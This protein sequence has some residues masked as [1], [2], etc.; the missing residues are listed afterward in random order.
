MRLQTKLMCITIIP[1]LLLFSLLLFLSHR[2]ASQ[3]AITIAAAYA[4]NLAMQEARPFLAM[5][6]RGYAVSRGLAAIAAGL[7]AHSVTDR[8]LAMALVRQTQ[9]DNLDFMGSWLMFEPNAL[10]GSD[11]RYLPEHNNNSA[12]ELYGQDADYTLHDAASIYGAINIYWITDDKGTGVIPVNSG[13]TTGFDEPYYFLA[14]N[15]RKTA[16][17][18]AYMDEDAHALITSI[19]S[20]ILL[21]DVFLGVAGVDIGLAFLQ[22][23]V[24]AIKPLDSGFLTVYSATGTVLASPEASLLGQPMP[25]STPEELRRAILEGKEYTYIAVNGPENREYLHF[26]VPLKYADDQSAWNFVVSLPLDKLLAESSAAIFLEIVITILGLIG[27]LLL[28][29]ILIRSMIRGLTSAISY[30]NTIASGDL[31]ASFSFKRQDEVGELA[32]SLRKMTEWMRE[33]LRDSH[34]LVEENAHARAKTEEHLALIEAKSN[35]DS[36]RNKSVAQQVNQAIERAM[37][38]REQA[39]RGADSLEI[40]NQS[41]Q[42]IVEGG[43]KLQDILGSLGEHANGV[44]HIMIAISG[45]ADQTN[46]LA[47]NAAVEAARAGTAGRGFAVVASEV[48]TLAERTIQSVHEVGKVTSAIQGNAKD[49]VSA[50]DDFL[51]EILR[52][53]DVSAESVV[54]LK[55]IIE[56]VEQ[57]CLEVREI[58]TLM[59]A[60]PQK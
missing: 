12:Q 46:L 21:D 38:A 42:N 49:S 18:D 36:L 17:P 29:I 37:N 45:I 26:Q 58:S 48:R 57:S 16:F 7:K 44:S 30:A 27:V 56:T 54:L 19:S 24:A 20:P 43:Q 53:A 35:E 52:T 1:L 39:R 55:Q 32:D 8:G 25:D 6:N 60:G 10:D 33:S 5:L 11:E 40:V 34:K 4:E 41:V 15:S 51:K 28:I 47:L 14:K 50:M 3:Q 22:E 2:T 59:E 31:D 9:L 23:T 13:D